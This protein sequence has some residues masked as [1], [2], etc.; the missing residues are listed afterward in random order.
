M[1]RLFIDHLERT[2]LSV[3]MGILLLISLAVVTF[4]LLTDIAYA[5]LDPRIRY[6]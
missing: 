2:D 6:N 5:W 1:G 4:Q 3:V